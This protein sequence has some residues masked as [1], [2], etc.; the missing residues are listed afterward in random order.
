[1]P[2]IVAWVVRAAALIAVL[3]I[4][5]P[6]HRPHLLS[7]RLGAAV[8][9]AVFAAAMC[10]AGTMLVLAGGLRRRKHRAWALTLGAVGVATLTHLRAERWTVVAVNLAVLVLLVWTRAEFT[11]RSERTGRLAALR[12]LLVMGTVSLTAGLLLTTRAAPRA[13]WSSRLVEVLSGLVGFTPELEFGREFSSLFTEIALN[14]LG[15]A[16]ALLT[17]V[18]F[19]APVRK[20]ARLSAD[21]E[22]RLRSLLARWG[23]RDSLGYFALR[24]DKLAMFS[25]SGKAAVSYRVVGGV[26]L[27]SGDPLGDPEAW[28]QAI[29]AWLAEADSYAWIPGVVGASEE[30]AIAYARAGLDSFELGD[31]AV[32]E[33]CEFSLDGRSMRGVRQ[34]VNRARRA[35]YTVEVSRQKDLSDEAIAEVRRVAE[36]WR[37][38]EVER[39]FS[40]A[41]GRLGDPR[42]GDVVLARCLDGQGH[43]VGLLTFVPWGPGG[44]SL[45]LMRRAGDS[46]N[47]V[48]ECAVVGVTEAAA[49][50]GVHR[51]SLNFAVFRAVFERGSR[52]GAGPMLRL[53]HRVLLM[54]SRWWQIESLY[55]ANAKYAPEWRPRFVCFRRA[56]E[57]ARVG[58]AALEAEA[59]IQQ[60]RWRWLAR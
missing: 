48:M 25:P 44:L 49:E 20:P 51:I 60:P 17:L 26:S 50:L 29:T 9:G 45:D 36:A 4:L 41:L 57:L 35:G 37:G 11:A 16:T 54:A 32:L 56:G 43:P 55:R 24:G 34:A 14:S 13:S 6:V 22:E 12:V 53:W 52:V 59:F 42:D 8:D 33:L 46:E 1:V 21:D 28:P 5:Q 10:A 2:R 47:G 40:M 15:A 27:A 19:L 31:E 39:G 30:G 38:E 23:E 7:W 58:L 18:A 3:D